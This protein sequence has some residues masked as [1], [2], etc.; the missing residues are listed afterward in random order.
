MLQMMSRKN[1]SLYDIVETL[2]IFHHNADDDRKVESD[3][4]SLSQKMILQGLIESLGG[5]I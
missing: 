3:G 4:G 1:Q 2:K 5:E